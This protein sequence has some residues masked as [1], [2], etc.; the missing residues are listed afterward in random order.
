MGCVQI[1]DEKKKYDM[2]TVS[3]ITDVYIYHIL[4]SVFRCNYS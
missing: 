2:Y 3:V 1:C 4:R